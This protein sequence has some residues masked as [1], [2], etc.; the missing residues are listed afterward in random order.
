MQIRE[1]GHNV[2]G[3]KVF[4]FWAARD[5]ELIGFVDM[6]YR[7]QRSGIAPL[8]FVHLFLTF[9]PSSAVSPVDFG[10]VWDDVRK[11]EEGVLEL[12]VIESHHASYTLED[13]VFR[14]LDLAK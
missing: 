5:Q 8:D 13:A 3:D 4:A 2:R 1:F 12:L 7:A 14:K 6:L 10:L 9:P 11:H